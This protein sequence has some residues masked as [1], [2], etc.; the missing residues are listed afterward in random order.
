MKRLLSACLAY[1]FALSLFLSA[2]CYVIESV[3]FDVEYQ[4]A[5]IDYDYIKSKLPMNDDEIDSVVRTVVQYL[6]GDTDSIQRT[7]SDGRE[8]YNERELLHMDDVIKLFHL[9]S[10][11]KAFCIGFCMIVFFILFALNGFGCF[12]ILCRGCVKAML[13]MAGIFVLVG[14]WYMI[15]FN[16]FWT[17][18]HE[19]AFTN[20]LWLMM[21]D[22]ALIIFYTA[23][24][25]TVIVR[26]IIEKLAVIL[27]GIFVCSLVGW[28]ILPVEKRKRFGKKNTCY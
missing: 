10:K 12:K 23:E 3:S 24:F 16:S 7:L 20:D 26:K 4:L 2:F 6:K 22:D 14:I 13:S 27:G 1:V 18:F 11:A 21:P 25:F 15:D 8:L 5:N 28:I 17:A 9:C 19:I